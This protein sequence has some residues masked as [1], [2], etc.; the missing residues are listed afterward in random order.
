MGTTLLLANASFCG[1][2]RGIR[3]VFRFLVGIHLELRQEAC[4]LRHAP[5]YVS[6]GL[7]LKQI[8]NKMV[9]SEHDKSL[10]QQRDSVEKNLLRSAQYGK[11]EEICRS[12]RRKKLSLFEMAK[13]R[14]KLSLH[15]I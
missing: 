11:P 10:V 8:N 6:R 2:L 12:C 14:A 15:E 3:A 9:R 4:A 5:C 7:H 13:I 1:A